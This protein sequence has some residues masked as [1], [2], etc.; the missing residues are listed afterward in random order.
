MFSS[1]SWLGI[2]S[3]STLHETSRI[4]ASFLNEHRIALD[5]HTRRKPMYFS[6]QATGCVLSSNLQRNSCFP[7]A[8]TRM[9]SMVVPHL[10]SRRCRRSSPGL[11]TTV[12]PLRDRLSTPM[13][14]LW[15]TQP[16]H[17]SS[18]HLAYGCGCTSCRRGT[19]GA[20]GVA[21]VWMCTGYGVMSGCRA[22][23]HT[24]THTHTHQ[25]TQVY[26]PD[27][28]ASATALCCA[29][30]V[31]IRHIDSLRLR[32]TDGRKPKTQP[33]CK[34]ACASDRCEDNTWK[35]S[36]ATYV[37]THTRAGHATRAKQRLPL[38]GGLLPP[39]CLILPR[40]RLVLRTFPR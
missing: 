39:T 18:H 20:G 9:P 30:A 36:V 25:W 29:S 37:I 21:H 15:H 19:H 17:G 11:H 16:S 13:P 24:H 34:Q 1:S 33:S 23:T 12:P 26:R 8:R 35:G 40:W 3:C 32:S 10:Q 38:S 28:T 2:T 14:A 5:T 7:S 22:R 6:L 27:T 31:H 4:C